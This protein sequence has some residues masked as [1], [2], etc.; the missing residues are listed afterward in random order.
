VSA[1]KLPTMAPLR[2]AGLGIAPAF[3]SGAA[4]KAAAE[5]TAPAPAAT[6]NYLRLMPAPISIY[7]Y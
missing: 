7:L 2:D 6:S 1:A 3:H 4:P 5:P